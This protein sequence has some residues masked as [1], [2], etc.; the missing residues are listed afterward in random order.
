MS[1]Q[2]RGLEERL[3]LIFPFPDTCCLD[4]L[5]GP[6]VRFFFPK[7]WEKQ[8]QGQSRV[9][10]VEVAALALALRDSGIDPEALVRRMKETQ[11]KVIHIDPWNPER[12]GL[13]NCVTIKQIMVVAAELL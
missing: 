11:G 6:E 4:C 13:G 7:W 3:R 9:T 2:L 1:E 8:P 10:R 5:P 12:G